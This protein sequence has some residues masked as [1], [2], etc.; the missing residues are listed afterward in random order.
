MKQPI[1]KVNYMV[2]II[3]GNSNTGFI[4]NLGK[5][6][7]VSPVNEFFF[8]LLNLTGLLNKHRQNYLTKF[9]TFLDK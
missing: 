7:L 3:K 6:F 2:F 8:N 1:L 4:I 9:Y 5:F